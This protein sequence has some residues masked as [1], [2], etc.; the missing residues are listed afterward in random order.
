MRQLCKLF[1]AGS[2]PA[3]STIG[4]MRHR[5]R[6]ENPHPHSLAAKVLLERRLEEEERAQWVAFRMA[7]LDRIKAT[8]G[9]LKCHYCG[10]DGLVLELPSDAKKADLKRLATVDHVMPRSKGGAEMDESNLVVAC[11]TCNQRKADSF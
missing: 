6:V 7:F 1:G 11:H 3:S 4:N 10:R 2:S 8:T 9:G 5:V